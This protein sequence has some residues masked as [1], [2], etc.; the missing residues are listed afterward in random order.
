MPEYDHS[1]TAGRHYAAGATLTHRVLVDA[2][3]CAEGGDW[4]GE[5]SVELQ[6]VRPRPPAARGEGGGGGGGVRRR[7]EARHHARPLRHHRRALTRHCTHLLQSQGPSNTQP[8]TVQEL[9]GGPGHLVLLHVAGRAFLTSGCLCIQFQLIDW[10]LF[11]GTQLRSVE[12]SRHLLVTATG[13]K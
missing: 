11:A 7:R 2:N 13:P 8:T 4:E 5:E 6:A 3:G 1:P 12:F 10:R 9:S